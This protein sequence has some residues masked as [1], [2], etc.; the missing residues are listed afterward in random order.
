MPHR[1]HLYSL[2][3]LCDIMPDLGRGLR[4]LS[5][6]EGDVESTYM[7]TFQVRALL[8]AHCE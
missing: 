4:T 3:D 7:Q 5:S 6:F 8:F 1:T 2:L